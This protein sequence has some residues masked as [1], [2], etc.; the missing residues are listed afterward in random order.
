[1]AL[2]GVAALTSCQSPGQPAESEAEAVDTMAVLSVDSVEPVV[3]APPLLP[4]PYFNELTQLIAAR[5]THDSLRLFEVD[6]AFYVEYQ[7]RMQKNFAKI[8]DD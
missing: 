2:L 1:M 3:E 6:S 4:D 8:E 5:A 7:E